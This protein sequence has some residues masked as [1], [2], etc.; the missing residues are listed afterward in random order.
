[1]YFYS[2]LK[3]DFDIVFQTGLYR[4]VKKIIKFLKVIN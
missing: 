4:I 3:K 2:F 1:M